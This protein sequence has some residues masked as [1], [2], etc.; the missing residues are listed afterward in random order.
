MNEI[1]V[2]VER[3]PDVI[4]AECK[5]K[6]QALLGRE[7]QPAQVEQLMLQFIVYREVLLTNRFNAGM[8]QMLYQFSRAPI[9]D[10]IAG[11][12]AVERLPA[13]YAG[14]TV[15]FDLVEGHGA[16]LIPEGTRVATDDNVI[17]RTVDDVAIPDHVHAVE[18]NALADTA[19]K[20]GNG[21]APGTVAKIL[22]PLAFVSTAA[23]LDTTGGGS[24]VETDEQLRERIKLA[25]SQYSSAGSRSSYKFYAT[26]ANPLITDVSITSPTPGTVVIVPLTE[27]DDTPEQ[28][29]TDV[30]AACSPEDVRP[31]TDTVI[32]AAPTRMEYAIQVDVTLYDNADATGTQADITAALRDYA[33]EKRRKLGQDIIR[34]H[35]AQ[36]CRIGAVYDVAVTEPAENIVVTDAAFATCTEIAVN[37]TGFNRG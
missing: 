14:C 20:G 10:Y 23:N 5:A 27:N 2:F 35:I 30:Y 11:L 19:G 36:I 22:D 31:L 12:V 37:I 17:F 4:M 32:V 9:L 8:A 25:P 18:V 33:A 6:L 28:I 21:Y 7:L 26:S 16:V 1:P 34:S 15:R 24:D 29:I 3:D 13:A